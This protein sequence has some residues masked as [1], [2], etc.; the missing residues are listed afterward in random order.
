[1]I[2]EEIA[3]QMLDLLEEMR[4]PFFKFIKL[5]KGLDYDRR[6]KH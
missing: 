5:I 4:R 3:K 2:E 6:Y 1:M